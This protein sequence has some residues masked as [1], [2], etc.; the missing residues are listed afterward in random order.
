MQILF[1]VATIAAEDNNLLCIT[2]KREVS[3]KQYFDQGELLVANDKSSLSI[4][5]YR[6]AVRL[7]PANSIY[8][9][10]LVV[11][12]YSTGLHDTIFSRMC[13]INNLGLS[14][15][16][17]PCNLPPEIISNF[18]FSLCYA[19]NETKFDSLDS[20]SEFDGPCVSRNVALS[21]SSFLNN[22][23]NKYG[24]IQEHFYPQ[25]MLVPPKKRYEVP[26]SEAIDFLDHPE[27]AY[28]S[29]DISEPGTYI[30]W[31]LKNNVLAYIQ[32]LITIDN[33]LSILRNSS[34]DELII[35][36][37]PNMQF[38]IEDIELFH[39]QAHWSMLLIGET[40]AG[41]FYHEDLLS[42]GSYQIQL[43][44]SKKWLICPPK[45][46][47]VPHADH[48]SEFCKE[49]I[50]SPGDLVYYPAGYGHQT[51]CIEGPC[52]SLSSSIVH[53]PLAFKQEILEK[54]C[55]NSS[56]PF[57]FPLRFC[58]ADHIVQEL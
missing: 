28:I 50:I 36:A 17:L 1:F 51:E 21:E 23:I 24:N 57:R 31:T 8:W 26:L 3:A 9:C 35:T 29:S 48:H 47:L 19:D 22:L 10:Q 37:W 30:Q 55:G 49:A 56:S 41:M 27:G 20:C 13:A 38:S 16:S 40:K 18:N 4:P 43:F 15:T 45:L 33:D 54:H 32:T 46:P 44:G 7:C 39:L 14:I 58:Q 52:I 11:I 34:V 42:L 6:A 2:Q 53:D 5:F 12:E 25:N